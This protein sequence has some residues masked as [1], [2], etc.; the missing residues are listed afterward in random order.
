MCI[1]LNDNNEAKNKTEMQ[2]NW[3]T[4]EIL[5]LVHI[6]TTSSQGEKKY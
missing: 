2:K 6:E 1:W 4:S 5:D 3:V